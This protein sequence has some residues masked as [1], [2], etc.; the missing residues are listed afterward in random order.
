VVNPYGPHAFFGVAG[1]KCP[2]LN[3]AKRVFYG[4]FP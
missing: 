2:A 4:V 3:S 1:E